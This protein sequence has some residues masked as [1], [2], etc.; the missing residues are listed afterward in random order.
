MPTAKGHKKYIE[1]PQRMWELFEMYK[2]EVNANPLK[3]KDWVGKDAH[4]VRRE[5]IRALTMEGFECFC[6]DH[7]AITYPDLN[8]FFSGK[9][10][11]YKDYF[12]ICSRIKREI[13]ADQIDKGLAGLIN[14]SITQ[15]LN[16]LTDK[17]ETT[18]IQEPPLFGDE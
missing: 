6:M 3:N 14:P 11:K 12:G 9:D 10:E 8:R 17:Q 13:R 7:T 5:Y 18:V 15:R 1:S 2:K 16:G 4:E